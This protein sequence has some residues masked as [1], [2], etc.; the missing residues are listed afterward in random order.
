MI[1]MDVELRTRA[2]ESDWRVTLRVRLDR[3]ETTALFMDGDSLISWPTE[4]LRPTGA[5]IGRSSMFLSEI[6]ARGEGLELAYGTRELAERVS[7]ILAHQLRT[8][9]PR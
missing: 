3:S 7:Q 8:A 5:P 9:L 1:S 4:G 2:E 6:V